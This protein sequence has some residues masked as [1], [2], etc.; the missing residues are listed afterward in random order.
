ML[1]FNIMLYENIE[2]LVIK[3]K[4]CKRVLT[5]SYMELPNR[6]I[7]KTRPRRCDTRESTSRSYYAID[8]DLYDVIRQ[9]DKF[10]DFSFNQAGELFLSLPEI[11]FIGNKNSLGLLPD[12]HAYFY[13]DV[14]GLNADILQRS[15]MLKKYIVKKFTHLPSEFSEFLENKSKSLFPVTLSNVSWYGS[16]C[17]G[18]T[19]LDVTN[20][21]SIFYSSIFTYGLTQS[22]SIFNNDINYCYDTIRLFMLDW[23]YKSMNNQK[24][25]FIDL[26]DSWNF[27]LNT[28]NSKSVNEMIAKRFFCGTGHANSHFNFFYDDDID[29]DEEWDWYDDDI[30]DD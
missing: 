18:G 13:C 20:F 5:F 12:P 16:V 7:D 28:M 8:H 3:T 4:P 25:K 15:N 10:K 21:V 30:D 9:V 22:F 6:V 19:N 11:V 2:S 29:E 23:H 24:I 14:D 26:V 17:L 27:A 1:K